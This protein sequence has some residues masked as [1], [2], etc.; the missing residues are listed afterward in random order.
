[1]NKINAD[2]SFFFFWYGRLC[3][4]VDGGK[5]KKDGTHSSA[6]SVFV[7][8]RQRSDVFFH[9]LSATL[10]LVFLDRN[11]SSQEIRLK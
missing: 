3:V 7:D 10:W 1:M 6:G 9:L 11:C 4:E 5:V 2:V 8:Q